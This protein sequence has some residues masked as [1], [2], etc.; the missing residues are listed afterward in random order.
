M[1]RTALTVDFFA[2]VTCPWCYVGWAA[3]KQAAAAHGELAV[4]VSWRTFMLA[5][6]MPEG[7][8]DRRAYLGQHFAPERLAAARTALSE[9]AAA[10]QVELRLDAPA[11][12]PRTL[13]VHRLIHWASGQGVAERAI[14]ALFHAYWVEGRDIGASEELVRVGESVGMDPGEL[15]ARFSTESDVALMLEFHA[16]A[17]GI[18][19]TGVPVAVMNRRIPVMGA[20]AAAV[21]EEA[22]AAALKPLS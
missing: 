15:K 20:Q 10:A 1:N 2:D 22:F 18:G 6:D 5:P 8:V 11:R 9:A 13:D 3:L 17:Q 21:F 16:A 14:D 12:I 4:N 7:G 19:V